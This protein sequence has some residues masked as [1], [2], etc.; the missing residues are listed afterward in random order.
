MGPAKPVRPVY[1]A[2]GSAAPGAGK[3]AA[4]AKRVALATHGLLLCCPGWSVVV[5]SQLTGTSASVTWDF[6]VL[7]RM[8]VSCSSRSPDL[9]I[10]LPWPP[11]NFSSEIIYL[12][13]ETEL[14]FVSQAGVQWCNF[15]SLQPPPSAFNS[16]ASAFRV[17]GTI[18]EIGLHHVGEAGLKLLTSGD[19]PA[20]ASQ[21]SGITGV[22]HHAW[23][24]SP[25]FKSIKCAET[26]IES[27]LPRLECSGRI[28]A[29]CN[30]HLLG[31]KTEFCHAGQAGFELLTSSD[32]P[33]SV[34][35][36]AG[37]TGISHRAWQCVEPDLIELFSK[38]RKY[39]FRQEGKLVSLALSPRLECSG[40]ILAY[41]N[42]CLPGSSDSPAS[43]S[44]VAGTTGACHCAQ[45]VFVFFIETG[46]HHIGQAGLELLT[47][48]GITGV[49]HHLATMDFAQAGVQ[50]CGLGSLQPLPPGFKRVSCL[51]LLSSWDYRHVPPHLANFVVLVETG[52]LHVGQAGLELLTSGDP[53]TSASQST[54]ITDVG[55]CAWP[56]VSF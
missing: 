49:S 6:T 54:G 23:L 45:L 30:R 20:L 19:P 37:I 9:V 53:P 32:L 26:T 28:S 3:R 55:H 5:Q 38:L 46:F 40:M 43:A 25:V 8:I 21:S 42:L 33:A 27:L 2:L 29:H 22:S 52:F 15:G 18:V 50:W 14:H 12:F 31:S 47:F 13:I 7:A 10:C 39:T 17:A 56:K 11:K 4:P 16:P 1:A 24:R 51:S 36:N 48:A 44:L 35:Q 41:C 34:S